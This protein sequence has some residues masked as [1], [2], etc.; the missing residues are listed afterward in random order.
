[1]VNDVLDCVMMILSGP[2]EK[3]TF[4]MRVDAYWTGSAESDAVK[5]SAWSNCG[6]R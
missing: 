2:T 3:V 1:M 6:T 4:S 5:D